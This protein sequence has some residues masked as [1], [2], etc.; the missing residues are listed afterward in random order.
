MAASK[1]AEV[2]GGW[3]KDPSKITDEQKE[4]LQL[5]VFRLNLLEKEAAL[6]DAAADKFIL[7]VSDSLV[8]SRDNVTN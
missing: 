5:L 6:I 8:S 4:T 1:I 7:L 3:I 2:F